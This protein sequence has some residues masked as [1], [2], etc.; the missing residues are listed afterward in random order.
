MPQQD[1]GRARFQ[2]AARGDWAGDGRAVQIE[3]R[4]VSAS[5][6]AAALTLGR[7]RASVFTPESS[8]SVHLASYD[9]VLKPSAATGLVRSI[10]LVLGLIH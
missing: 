5:A 1:Q 9:S 3:V 7:V 4:L 2:P 10:G 6:A 8:T